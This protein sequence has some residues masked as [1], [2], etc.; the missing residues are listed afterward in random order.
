MRRYNLL[1]EIALACV[2]LGVVGGVLGGSSAL[3]GHWIASVTNIVSPNSVWIFPIGFAPLVAGFYLFRLL[4][5]IKKRRQMWE[6]CAHNVPGGV[7]FA[8]CSKCEEER[9]S[10]DAEIKRAAERDYQK[11]ENEIAAQTITTQE[12]DRLRRSIVPSIEELR[13]LSPQRFEDEIARMF[14]RLGYV[15]KQ[16][17]YSNDFGRDVILSKGGE[18]FLLECKRYGAAR[19]SGRPELQKFHSAMI[20]DRA[21]RGFFV[22][23]GS[24]SKDALE[25]SSTVSIEPIDWKS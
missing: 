19:Q 16:T 2:A 3:L 20:S 14:E 21:K 24:F 18:K 23:T 25:F 13:G 8:R 22:T 12:L 15:V 7:A 11:S 4:K 10:A 17:P 1:D 5:Y 9:Q 6:P